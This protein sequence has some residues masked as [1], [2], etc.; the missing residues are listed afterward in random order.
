MIGTMPSAARGS[1]HH[2]PNAGERDRREVCAEGRLGRVRFQGAASERAR[3]L[4]ARPGDQR[5]HDHRE[6]QNREA[7][8]TGVRRVPLPE[9]RDALHDHVGR[10]SEKRS[11]DDAVRQLLDP[12]PTLGVEIR[13]EPPVRREA[14]CHLDPAVHAEAHEGDASGPDARGDRHRGLDGVVA[15]G[16]VVETNA[17]ADE[18]RTGNRKPDHCRSLAEDAAAAATSG[19]PLRMGVETS[20]LLAHN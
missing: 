10:E 4:P 14:G 16:E 1:A 19:R 9:R 20:K 17:P 3:H 12:F 11:A 18:R 2:Q 15:D 6:Q 7:D 13:P 5:H 8:R